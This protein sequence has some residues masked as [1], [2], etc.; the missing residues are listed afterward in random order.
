MK[1]DEIVAAIRNDKTLAKH[2]LKYS[3]LS[4]SSTEVSPITLWRKQVDIQLDTCKN[5]YKKTIKR[6]IAN[7]PNL[8]YD[9]YFQKNDGSCPATITLL[10]T[11]ETQILLEKE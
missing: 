10:Y 2:I 8:F 6:I 5:I 7:N 3:W 1:K 4:G 9:G 11:D